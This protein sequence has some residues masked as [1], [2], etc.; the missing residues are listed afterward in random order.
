MGRPLVDLNYRQLDREANFRT[1]LNRVHEHAESVALVH[2]EEPECRLL[3][4]RRSRGQLPANHVGQP[5]PG[6]FHPGYNYLIQI[7]PVLIVAPLY[8]RGEVEFGW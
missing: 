7:I 4:R 3:R 2:W 5:Q 6:V 8:I 1:A